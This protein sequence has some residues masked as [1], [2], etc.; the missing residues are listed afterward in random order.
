MRPNGRACLFA[1]EYSRPRPRA[2][3]RLLRKRHVRLPPWAAGYPLPL[4][5]GLGRADGHPSAADRPIQGKEG[6]ADGRPFPPIWILCFRR[7]A[8]GEISQSFPRDN[9]RNLPLIMAGLF[10]GGLD[11]FACLSRLGGILNC[12]L[13]EVGLFGPSTNGARPGSSSTPNHKL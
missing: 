1:H 6:R 8:V 4:A 10:G 12:I 13:G 5:G 11:Y 7:R 3:L 9:P 2:P